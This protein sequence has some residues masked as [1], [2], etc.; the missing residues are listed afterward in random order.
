MERKNTEEDMFD[1]ITILSRQERIRKRRQYMNSWKRSHYASKLKSATQMSAGFEPLPFSPSETPGTVS[2][3]L[4]SSEDID[5]FKQQTDFSLSPALSINSDSFDEF[6]TLS[7]AK[8]EDFEL[9]L[10]N[11]NFVEETE[12]HFKDDQ[13]IEDLFDTTF[14]NKDHDSPGTLWHDLRTAV[15]KCNMTTVQIDEILKCLNNHPECVTAALPNSYKT[16]LKVSKTS[17]EKE[18]SVVSSHSYFYFGLRQQILF[19][20]DKFPKQE[21]MKLN[22]LQL[23]WNTDGFPLFNSRRVSSWPITIYISNLKPRVVFDIA[24]TAGD[25]KPSNL[26]YLNEFVE[27]LVD[28]LDTGID[29]NGVQLPVI[30]KA[31]VVDAP[32]RAFIKNV[33]Q[34]SSLYGCDQCEH[35]GQYD[36]KRVVWVGTDKG[37]SRTNERFRNKSQPSYHQQNGRETPLLKL[38]IDFIGHFPPDFMHQAGGAMKKMLLWLISGPR[39]SGNGKYLCRMS[40]TNVQI[41]NDRI[42][43]VA[44]CMPNVFARKLRSTTEIAD[45][46]YTELRQILLYSGKVLFINL[47]ANYPQYQH[48][49]MFSVVCNLMVDPDKAKHYHELQRYLMKKVILGFSEYYGEAFMTYNIHVLQHFPDVA[50]FHGS[51]DEVSAY[52]FESHLGQLKKSITSSHNPLVSLVKGIHRT[53]ANLTGV[54]FLKPDPIISTKW[55]NNIYIDVKKHKVYEAVTLGMKN[56]KMKEYIHLEPFFRKPVT[57]FIVGCYITKPENWRFSYVEHEI[58]QEMRQGIKIEMDGFPGLSDPVLTKRI[59]FMSLMHNQI[60]A[61]F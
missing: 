28:V 37:I 53:Q 31:C 18:L 58:V 21:V 14:E 56:I 30:H 7:I 39:N 51:L 5:L 49:L 40:A 35:V 2:T 44:S 45:Y 57:S 15:Q 38:D 1:K 59:L 10:K 55:P 48:F 50:V 54:T 29:F 41:L 33:K 12:L 32:A 13:C 43:Y 17:M 36:G 6:D 19:Y 42:K 52:P 47:M 3:E 22:Q 61:L 4:H 9:N 24:L 11:K 23:V 20:L 26:D 25:G 27:E 60:D 16:L 46:K 34:F 8:I